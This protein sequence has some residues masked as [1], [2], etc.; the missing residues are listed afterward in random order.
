MVEHVD[1]MFTQKLVSAFRSEKDRLINVEKKQL[2]GVARTLYLEK[3]VKLSKAS[4]LA[5]SHKG[6]GLTKMKKVEKEGEK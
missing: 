3:K 1:I 2:K 4:E 6:L 5:S